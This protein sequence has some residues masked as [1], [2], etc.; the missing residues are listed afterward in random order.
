LYE[1]HRAQTDAD[2]VRR[3]REAGAI[4][5]GKSNL[6]ELAYGATCNNPFYGAVRN[7]WDLDRIPG[8]S[9][10]GTGAALA[11]DL[12]A[13]ALGTD[14]GG[15]VRLPAAFVGGSGIRPTFGRVSNRGVYPVSW[16]LD[17]VGPMARAV[18]DVAKVFS[19]IAGYDA[20]DP[21]KA[22]N[23]AVQNARR[24]MAGL[25]ISA[26]NFFSNVEPEIERITRDALDV[27][28][29]W[30]DD[31]SKSPF[32]TWKKSTPP[33][34]RSF[35]RGVGAAPQTEQRQSELFGD[36]VL[37][38]LKRGEGFSES[39][40]R[41]RFSACF[42][43]QSMRTVFEQV[44]VIVTPTVSVLAPRID[45]SEALNAAGKLINGMLSRP[46]SVRCPSRAASAAA[47]CR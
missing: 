10:G 20:G 4:V 15:S 7:P 2:T 33:A 9:S 29:R 47:G 17:T 41:W 1:H 25:R 18:E 46:I 8:G 32:R 40:S 36:D 31:W 24:E 39:T 34:R 6:H 27:F 42:L 45:E 44:D 13:A 35:Q 23:G 28:G 26:V 37:T 11:A 22:S 14:T 16:S 12:C 38:R 5:L 19:I 30:E 3:L 21:P 43:Q